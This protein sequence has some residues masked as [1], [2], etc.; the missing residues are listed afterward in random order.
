MKIVITGGHITPAL[1]VIESLP[2]AAEIVLVGRKHTFESDNSLSFEYE[3]I[4]KRKVPF[5]VLPSSRLQRSISRHTM[6][7]LFRLPNS[8]RLAR[9]IL[10]EE[11]PN[12][13]LSFGGYIGLPVV[14]AAATL[15]IPIVIH[16]QTTRAGF[17]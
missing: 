17:S 5:R 13:I 3:E 11:K 15:S 6:P 14:L 8:V 10:K 7:S 1:A 12:V 2:K 16:E 4:S 9:N